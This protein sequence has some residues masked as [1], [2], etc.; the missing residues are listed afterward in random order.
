MLESYAAAIDLHP[1]DDNFFTGPCILVESHNGVDSN[2]LA[3]PLRE[4]RAKLG[5][6]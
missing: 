3:L 4:V 6:S 5:I 2:K 1:F